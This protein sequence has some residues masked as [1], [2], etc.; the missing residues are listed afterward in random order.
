MTIFGT[1]RLKL[2]AKI[3]LIAVMPSAIVAPKRSNVVCA[4]CASCRRPL[5]IL[6]RKRPGISDTTA[7]KPMAAKGI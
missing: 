6:N 3:I 7:A 1:M 2:I 5:A 4:F